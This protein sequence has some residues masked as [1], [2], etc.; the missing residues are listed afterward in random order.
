M[1]YRRGL[2]LADLDLQ[3]KLD[4]GQHRIQPLVA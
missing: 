1:R 4:L 3:A 2:I